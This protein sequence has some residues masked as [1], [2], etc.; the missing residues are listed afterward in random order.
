[1]KKTHAFLA[2]ALAASMLASACST[3]PAAET[4][5][6]SQQTTQVLGETRQT[7]EAVASDTQSTAPDVTTT[8]AAGEEIDVQSY[9]A[10]NCGTFNLFDESRKTIAWFEILP[11]GH[12]AY[13]LDIENVT[14]PSPCAFGT[15]ASIVK[16][17]DNTYNIEIGAI[18]EGHAE[19]E[20]WTNTCNINGTDFTSE[21]VAINSEHVS[22]HDVITLYCANSNAAD[23]PDDYLHSYALAF[24]TAYEEL[25]AQLTNRG[26]YNPATGASFIET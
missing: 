1:M 18:N 10:E 16:V 17:D 24:E 4:S 23:L 20:V 12:F 15:I 11:D 26:L 8:A 7:E 13:T 19:G 14:D 6:M 3:A 25:P 22:E 9:C 5:A 21:Y 2:S